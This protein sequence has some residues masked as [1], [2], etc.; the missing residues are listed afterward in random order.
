VRWSQLSY[1]SVFFHFLQAFTQR[2]SLWSRCDLFACSRALVRQQQFARAFT[3][4]RPQSFGSCRGVIELDYVA[5]AGLAL[6]RVG[7]WWRW[8]VRRRNQDLFCNLT[9]YGRL[10]RFPLT[11]EELNASWAKGKHSRLLFMLMA[12][13]DVMSVAQ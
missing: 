9:R 7:L 13:F 2:A 8:C 5:H 4:V 11:R 6:K 10:H 3:G 12:H 1:M